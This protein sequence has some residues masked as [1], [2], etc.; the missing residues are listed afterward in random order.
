MNKS[1]T[2]LASALAKAIAAL[3]VRNTFLEDLHGGAT[4]SSQTGDFSDVKVVTPFGEIPWG[5]LSRISDSEMQ[6]LMKEV[7]DKVFTSHAS[8]EFFAAK[9]S[10]D[11]NSQPA[12]RSGHHHPGL[13]QHGN[14]PVQS[15]EVAA[16]LQVQEGVLSF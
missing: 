2:A 15:L 11:S 12:G 5:K 13:V 4:P 6:R 7:V 16:A 8:P 14:G 1:D 10:V 9:V 3:C